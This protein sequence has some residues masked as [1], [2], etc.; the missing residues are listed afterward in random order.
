MAFRLVV[1]SR[2]AHKIREIKQLTA[3]LPLE[4]VGVAEL[5]EVPPVEEDGDTFRANAEKKAVQ[6][7]RFLGEWVLADD[8]GLE[9]DALGG[10][11]GVHSARFSGEGRGDVANNELLLEK[12]GDLP[13]SQRGAQFRCVIALASPRGEV[14]FSEGICRGVIGFAPKGSNGFGYDPLFIV[15]EQGCTFA[16]LSSEEKNRISHRSRAMQG[17][18]RILE[19]LCQTQ[20]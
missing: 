4:V 1:A 15:P 13:L 8:S 12:L 3:H 9:V 7:A 19:R 5:G 14:Q 18:L 11:P 10:A 20:A 6:T 2:N 16:E 17:M